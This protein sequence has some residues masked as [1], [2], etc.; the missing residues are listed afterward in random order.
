MARGL[1]LR[2]I[3]AVLVLGG[4]LG[5]EY[6]YDDFHHGHGVESD[7]DDEDLQFVTCGS[8]IQLI[9]KA[10]SYRL[11]SHPINYG[12][13]SGQMSVTGFKDIADNNNYWIVR[14]AHGETP[15]KQG[16]KIAKGS[17]I[18]LKHQSTGAWLHSHRHKSP[19]G[20]GQEVSCYGEEHRSDTG[21]NWDV[22][23]K[24]PFWKREGDFRL[25][26]KDTSMFLSSH[27][28]TFSS[29][30]PGQYEIYGSPKRGTENLWKLGEGLFWAS[31]TEENQMMDEL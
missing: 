19:Y 21:D 24:G 10:T 31:E 29:P 7:L 27:R 14:E 12:S 15:C 6:D 20:T 11:H 2:S 8:V 13:G 1:V 4:I 18:R 5:Y 16:E 26:H 28:K 22:L 9:H 25:Q 23:F 17:T 30:I 3:L